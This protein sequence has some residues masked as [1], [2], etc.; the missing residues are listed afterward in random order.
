MDAIN[1]QIKPRTVS[2][3][4]LAN[5]SVDKSKNEGK[6]FCSLEKVICG[7]KKPQVHRV[8]DSLFDSVSRRRAEA[9]DPPPLLPIKKKKIRKN[10]V[11]TAKS[12][13]KSTMSKSP[14][15]E[16]ENRHNVTP[17]SIY[18]G[19]GRVNNDNMACLLNVKQVLGSPVA[20]LRQPSKQHDMKQGKHSKQSAAKDG[21]KTNH[22]TSNHF[23][24]M[25]S[26]DD[27]PSHLTMLQRNKSERAIK[28]SSQKKKDYMASKH[29][30]GSI[31]KIHFEDGSSPDSDHP[32]NRRSIIQRLCGKTHP[33]QT[34]ETLEQNIESKIKV[35]AVPKGEEKAPQVPDQMDSFMIGF[36]KH[37]DDTQ[38]NKSS[39]LMKSINDSTFIGQSDLF[40]RRDS[41]GADILDGL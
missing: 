23:P 5:N 1:F 4:Y 38:A 27:G 29:A 39:F 26:P 13:N 21:L 34:S 14:I 2:S 17:V 32:V 20:D 36:D 10:S 31:S 35:E 16:N 19:E 8:V 18:T 33:K 9:L 40:S 28:L 30:P 41:V 12:D 25:F 37:L 6:S 24:V 15:P 3:V 7:L 11:L 22:G